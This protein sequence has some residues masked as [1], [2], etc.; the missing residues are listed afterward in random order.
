MEPLDDA[1][2]D[3]LLHGLV[4]GLPVDLAARIWGR[5]EGVPLY[6]VETVRMLLDRGLLV[7]RGDSF[8]LTGPVDTLDVPES[9][10]SLIGCA[11]GWTAAG[12]TDA[13]AGRRGAR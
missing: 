7:R 3:E 9:L 12:A 4:P 6:A 1:A 10:Q 11:V 8:E 13:V 2:M 5:A